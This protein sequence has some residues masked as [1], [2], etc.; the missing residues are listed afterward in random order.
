MKIEG[1]GFGFLDLTLDE[2]KLIQTTA[3]TRGSPEDNRTRICP[4]MGIPAGSARR[5]AIQKPHVIEP[6]IEVCGGFCG[7]RPVGVK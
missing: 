2:L 3:T 1:I 7:L 6:E 5:S 4:A